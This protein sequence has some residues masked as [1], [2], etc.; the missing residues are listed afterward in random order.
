[1]GMPEQSI[2][3]DFATHRHLAGFAHEG[4]RWFTGIHDRIQEQANAL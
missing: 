1:M 4:A 2:S 3:G